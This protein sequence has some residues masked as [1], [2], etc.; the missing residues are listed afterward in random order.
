M[1]EQMAMIVDSSSKEDE[2]MPQEADWSSR[3]IRALNHKL[4]NGWR[5][6]MCCPMSGPESMHN[7]LALVILE[8][9]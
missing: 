2:N 7:T 3:S 6:V 1:R 9:G 5:V 8:K 4:S